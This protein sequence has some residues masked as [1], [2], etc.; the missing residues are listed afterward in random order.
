MRASPSSPGV[1]LKERGLSSVPG[2]SAMAFTVLLLKGREPF[3]GPLLDE[4]IDDAGFLNA[5][6]EIR[7]L[8]GRELRAQLLVRLL[9]VEPGCFHLTEIVHGPP[10]FLLPYRNYP[11][12]YRN[13]PVKV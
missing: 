11:V 9:L 4:A 2:A 8:R 3:P 10:L 7:L 12:P 13:S 6:A 5:H 1:S